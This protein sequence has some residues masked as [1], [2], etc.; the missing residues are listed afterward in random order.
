[1]FR[2]AK[3]VPNYYSTKFHE[4]LTSGS[5]E[6]S[7]FPLNRAVTILWLTA[8]GL[9]LT[10]FSI[11]LDPYK[12]SQ[13]GRV[14]SNSITFNA[15]KNKRFWHIANC[16]IVKTEKTL[17]QSSLNKMKWSLYRCQQAPC[18]FFSKPC[19]RA[20]IH[21]SSTNQSAR[22]LCSD[23]LSSWKEETWKNS[24][25]NS[26]RTHDLCDTSDDYFIY[27]LMFRK[28]SCA[29]YSMSA[30]FLEIFVAMKH[31]HFIVLLHTASTVF[32]LFVHVLPI[33][34]NIGL[35]HPLIT[36]CVSECFKPGFNLEW[37]PNY[38]NL[39]FE[40]ILFCHQSSISK[41]MVNYW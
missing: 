14:F 25:L 10:G 4:I 36:W 18:L 31:K 19:A 15:L 7:A 13:K 6:I 34:N 5:I 1:V 2:R 12:Q 8:H 29:K 28:N 23:P 3:R 37:R 16:L 33:Y 32:S 35:C 22:K 38:L 24:G 20:L 17:A 27:I 40:D 21:V 30:V 41:K 39:E 11:F 9:H 26:N